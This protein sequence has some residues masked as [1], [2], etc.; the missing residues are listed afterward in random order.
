M[1]D[2]ISRQDEQFPVSEH[3][4]RPD[5]DK[6]DMRVQILES[7]TARTSWDRDQ[8]RNKWIK[9]LLATDAG[10]DN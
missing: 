2:Q 6:S 10:E 9:K 4:S 5:H 3:F 8:A 7:G 1:L